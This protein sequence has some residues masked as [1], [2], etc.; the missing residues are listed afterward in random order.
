MSQPKPVV[1]QPQ[2]GEVSPKPVTSPLEPVVSQ[3][4]PVAPSPQPGEVSP[5]PVASS[6]QPGEVSPKPVASSPQPGE[7]SPKPVASSPKP[8]ASSPRP[9][10]AP[11]P[12]SPGL[13]PNNQSGTA[14]EDIAKATPDLAKKAIESASSEKTGSPPTAPV[15]EAAKTAPSKR[16]DIKSPELLSKTP[17]ELHRGAEPTKDGGLPRPAKS[18]DRSNA[19]RSRGELA[20]DDGTESTEPATEDG[21]QLLDEADSNKTEAASGQDAKAE[22]GQKIGQL[23]D[24]IILER[25]ESETTTTGGI[26]IP[27]NAAEKPDEGHVVAVSSGTV[28]KEGEGRPLE[29]KIGDTVLFGEHSGTEVTSPAAIAAIAAVVAPATAAVTAAAESAG[30]RRPVDL[31]SLTAGFGNGGGATAQ[32]SSTST[33]S[34][35]PANEASGS[36]LPRSGN[37][38]KAP[39]EASDDSS[40]PDDPNSDDDDA[41]TGPRTLVQA[42]Y[43]TGDMYIIAAALRLDPNLSV[44]IL[45]DDSHYVGT[46]K[47]RAELEGRSLSEIYESAKTTEAI[48]RARM[49]KNADRIQQFYLEAGIEPHRIEQVDATEKGARAAYAD[50][51]KAAFPD[52]GTAP[53]PVLRVPGYATSVVQKAFREDRYKAKKQLTGMFDAISPERKAQIDSYRRGLFGDDTIMLL[54]NRKTGFIH[55]PKNIGLDMNPNL[56]DQMVVMVEEDFGGRQPVIIG[57]PPDSPGPS[58]ERRT[59]SGRQLIEYWKELNLSF[60]EQAYFLDQ[61]REQNRAMAA[62]M[63]SGALELPALLGMPTVYFELS[64]MRQKGQRWMKMSGRGRPAG[65]AVPNLNQIEIKADTEHGALLRLLYQELTDWLD[66]WLDDDSGDQPPMSLQDTQ[67]VIDA[68]RD[69]VGPIEIDAGSDDG[70]AT[71]LAIE[72]RN[73]PVV[74]FHHDPDGP[75]SKLRDDNLEELKKGL[76]LLASVRGA[77]RAWPVSDE[78]RADLDRHVGELLGAYGFLPRELDDLRTL[79]HTWDSIGEAEQERAKLID[80]WSDEQVIDHLRRRQPRASIERSGPDGD[81]TLAGRSMPIAELRERLKADPKWVYRLVKQESERTLLADEPLQPPREPSRAEITRLVEETGDPTGLRSLYDLLGGPVFSGLAEDL[82]PFDGALGNVIDAVA[83]IGLERAEQA[84]ELVGPAAFAGVLFENRTSPGR[85]ELFVERLVENREQIEEQQRNTRSLDGALIVDA[86]LARTVNRAALA[87]REPGAKELQRFP[88]RPGEQSQAGQ[89]KTLRARGGGPAR[90]VLASTLGYGRVNGPDKRHLL[91]GLDAESELSGASGELAGGK[92]GAQEQKTSDGPSKTGKSVPVPV[93]PVTAEDRASPAYAEVLKA[94]YDLRIRNARRG[95]LAEL[96][97]VF[98]AAQKTGST[99]VFATGSPALLDALGMHAGRDMAARGRGQGYTSFFGPDGLTVTLGQGTVNVR[100]VE[101]VKLPRELPE[102][103]MMRLAETRQTAPGE[104]KL[105]AGMTLTYRPR[106]SSGEP[107]PASVLGY[108]NT[109]GLRVRTGPATSPVEQVL[110]SDEFDIVLD[111]EQPPPPR[112]EGVPMEEVQAMFGDPEIGARLEKLLD[113]ELAP[114]IPGI[115]HI[116]VRRYVD[117]ID[118]S[119]FVSTIVGGAVRD[120]VGKL[121]DPTDIDLSTTMPAMDVF[122]AMHHQKLGDSARKDGLPQASVLPYWGLAQIER[123]VDSGLDVASL[124]GPGPGQQSFDLA[125]DL[126]SRDFTINSLYY[127]PKTKQVLDPTGKGLDDLKDFKLRWT[128][129]SGEALEKK[130]RHD[131][132]Q[133]RR[134]IKFRMKKYKDAEGRERYLEPANRD[135]LKT[136]N[137]VLRD[138]LDSDQLTPE[139]VA[140]MIDGMG[141]SPSQVLD[142]A[143]HIGIEKGLLERL[144]AIPRGGAPSDASRSPEASSG[145]PAP[146]AGVKDATMA[147]NPPAFESS[148]PGALDASGVL[149]ASGAPSDAAEIDAG[150]LADEGALSDLIDKLKER[151]SAWGHPATEENRSEAKSL[152]E[153]LLRS[154]GVN[155]SIVKR[156][157]EMIMNPA[158]VSQSV[159]S[160]CVP[161][162]ILYSLLKSDLET[163]SHLVAAVFTGRQLGR[164]AS[165]PVDLTRDASKSAADGARAEVQDMARR[166]MTGG[167]PQAGDP[168]HNKLLFNGLKTAGAKRTQLAGDKDATASLD[169]HILDHLLGRSLGKLLRLHDLEQYKKDEATTE[170]AKPGY[171]A[172]GDGKSA[173][174]SSGQGGP[175]KK[176][177]DLL[178]SANSV[179]T[180]V[181]KPLGADATVLVAGEDGDHVARV[182]E[183]LRQT[184]RA[185]FAFATVLDGDALWK[186]AQKYEPG[187]TSPHDPARAGVIDKVGEVSPHQVTID[188]EITE[189]GDSYIVPIQSWGRSF[190]IQV[191]K[192]V[193]PELFV[194]FTVGTY[195]PAQAPAAEALAD[196]SDAP[197]EPDAGVADLPA[198]MPAPATAVAASDTSDTSSEPDDPMSDEDDAATGPRTIVQA[199]YM[200]GDM[201]IISA[202][203]RLDPDLSIRILWDNSHYLR[204]IEERAETEGRSVDEIYERAKTTP[205]AERARMKKN[206]DRIRAFY[207]EAGIDPNRIELVDVTEKGARAAYA[208]VRDAAFPKGGTAPDPVLRVPGYA[209]SVVQREFRKDRY[210]ARQKLAGMFEGISEERRGKID[211]YRKD[212]FGDSNIMLVWNRATGWT[213]GRKNIGLDTNPNLLDQMI[214]M[215]EEDFNGRLPVIIGDQP[216]DPGPSAKRIIEAP[217]LIEYWNKL[218]LSLVEQAYFLDQLREQNRAMAAGMI[219]GALELPALLGMPTVYFELSSMRQKGQRWTKMSGLGRP[220]GGAIP[221]LNQIE[222]K[223]DTE[224]GALLRLAYKELEEWLDDTGED[225]ARK[226]MS[227]EE[228]EKEI[229]AIRGVAQPT[230]FNVDSEAYDTIPLSD[231]IVKARKTAVAPFYHDPDDPSSSDAAVEREELAQA[232]ERL[233]RVRRVYRAGSVSK[234]VRGDL[235]RHRREHLGSYGFL[236]QELDDLRTLLRTWDSIGGA[237]QERAK[238][239][240]GWSDEQVIDHL[241]RRQPRAS[242]VRSDPGGD[243]TLAGRSMPIAELRERLKADPKW[244]YRLVKQES[245][246]TLLADEPLQLPGEPSRADIERIGQETKNPTGVEHLHELLGGPV[247]SGLVEDLRPFDGAL[248]SVIDA[249]DAIGPER[250]KQAVEL[251]GPAAF[252]GALF[253]NRTSPGRLELFVER[254]VENREQIE[255]QQRNTR[256]LDGALIVDARLARTVNRAALAGREPGAKELQRFPRR[257]GEQSQAGQ[258]KT[259]RA[260]GGGP[261]RE[262]LASTLGYSRV[263]GPDRRHLLFGL[264]AESELSSASGEL[265]GGKLGAQEQKKQQKTSDGPSKTGKSVPVPVLPV[266]AEDRASPAYA[267]VLKAVYDLRIRNARRSDLAELADVFFAAQKTRSTPV[268]ATGSPALL[269]ALGMHAGR[270]MAARKRGQGY[271]SF[272]GPDGLTVTLGQGTVNVRPVEAVKL[273]RELP[274]TEMMRLAETRKT[275]PGEQKLYAGMTLT[276]RRHGS[277]D[278]PE[279]A[280]VLGY[281]HDGQIR[282]RTGPATSPVEQVLSFDGYDIVLDKEQPPP[283]SMNGVPVADVQEMFGDPE[284]GARLEK[285]LD[286][287]LAPEIP[288]IEHIPVRRYVDMID[289]SGFISTIVGGAVRDVV[290]KLKDPTDIDL[291][292]TM[293]AMDVFTAMHQ[294]KLGDSARKDGLPQAS[295]LPYWGLAQ[296]ER[297]VDSG[298][299]VASLHGPGPGQQSFDLKEDLSSRDF[300]INSLYYD[301]KTKQVLDPTGKGLDDLKDFKLRWTSGS[302]EALEKKLRH[303]PPQIR[304]WIKFRMKKYKDAEGGERYL[305][306]ANRDD[307]KT[308]NDVLRDLLDS[309]QLTPED[310]AYM[311]DGMGASPSQVLDKAEHIGIEKGLLERLFAIPRGG[312]PSDASRSSEASSGAPAPKAGVKDATMAFSPPAFESSVLD[313]LG[314]LDAA[315]APSDAAKVDAG[316]L[317]DEGALSDLIDKLRE[318]SSTWGHPATEENRSEAKSLL[319]DLLRSQGVNPSIVKRLGEMIM[320]PASVSQSVF[321]TCV[322]QG[323]LYSLLKSDLETFSHL[324]AAVFTGRQLGRFASAPVDLTRD[325]SKSAAD[326]AKAEV[327]DMARRVMRGG[328]PQAGDPG[329]N[330]LLFNGLKTAGAKRTQLAG[331]KDATASLDRHVLDHLLGRSLGKLLRLHDLEQYKKDEATTEQAKPG[332]RAKGDGARATESS[333]Q[334]GPVKKQGDLLLSANSVATIVSKPLGA[335]A[336]VLVA[337]E[338]GDHVARVNEV[339]RQADRAPFAFA[340]VLDGEALWKEAQKYEPGTTSPHDAARAG[341]IDKVDGTSPHQVTIDGEITEDGDSYIVP[342]QSWGRSFSIQVKKDVMPEL[343]AAFTVGT[344]VPA[345]APAA[346]ALTKPADAPLGPDAGVADLP[347]GMPASVTGVAASDTSDTSSEPDD[348]ASDKDDAYNGPRTIVQAAYMTGDMYIITAALRLDPNLSVE[349]LW[350]DSHYVNTSKEHAKLEGRSLNEIYERS[351]TTEA[352]E[353]A[354]MKKNADRIEQFYRAAGIA[355]DRIKQVDAREKG[356]RAAY[357]EVRKAAFPKDGTEPDATL[358]VPGH[359]TSVVQKAFREDRYKAKK[360]LTAMFDAISPDRKKEIEAY[361]QKQFGDDPIMLLW[362]RKTGFIHG[363]KNIGLDTNPNL[364]DQMV[365]MVE[366][367]FK[368]RTP[369]ILGDQPDSPG[370]SVERRI[371]SGRQL[372]EYWKD[373]NLS[374]VE[375]AYFLDQLREHNRAMAAGMISGA[376]ELPALL[377]MPTVYFELSSMRQKAQRWMK[378]SGRGRPTGGAVPNLNQIEIKAD[379]EHGALLRLLHQELTDW[380]DGWLDD[381]D[382]RDLPPMSLEQTEA[383]IAAIRDVVEPIE[384]DDGSGSA[385]A[386]ARA[387]EMQK[388]LKPVIPF[389]HDPDGPGS[390]ARDDNLRALTAALDLVTLVRDAHRAWPVSDEVR[391]DLELHMQKQL[392]AYGFLLQELDDLRTMLRSWDSIGEAERERAKLIDGWSDEQVIDHLRRR[393][394]RASIERSDPG[395]EVVLA[396]SSFSVAE[397]RER[398]KADPKWVYGLVKEESKRTLLADTPLELPGEPSRAD[399]ERIGQETKNPTGVEHLHELLGGPVFSGLVEDLRPFKGALGNV[400]DAVDRIGPERAEQAV[401]LVG[402]AAFAGAL[403]E[404]RTSPGRLELFVERLVANRE[405]LE[406]QQRATGSVDGVLVVDANLARTMNR[407]ALAGREPGAAALKRFPR[408]PGE[409]SQA[410]QLQALRGP[411]GGEPRRVLASTLGY[412]RVNGPDKEHLLFGLDSQEE[413]SRASGEHDQDGAQPVGDGSTGKSVP[414]PV[415]PV[416]AEDRASPAYAEVLKAVY[417]LRIRNA[418]RSDLA[419]LAD[420][421]FAA[422]KTGATPVLATGSSALLDALGMHAGR[423]MEARKRKQSYT[424]FFGPEGLTVTLGQGTVNVRPVEAVKLPRQLSETELMR[425]AESR[426]TAPGEQKLYAGMTL[427]YRPRGSSGERKPASV[428]GYTHDGQLRVR[429]GPETSPAEQELSF[430]GYDIVLD[431]KQ[432]PPPSMGGVPVA[433]VQK[434]FA[435]DGIG[436]RLEELLDFGLAPEITEI[437]HFPVRRYV[438]MI[439]RSGFIATIVGG[440]VRDVVGKLKKP[441]DI[442]LSTTM[443]AMDVFAAMHHQ[444]LGDSARKGGLPQAS[445]LPYWG[446]AQIERQVDSGLDVASLHGPGPGQQSFDLKEDLSSR[447]F[448][449]NSLYYDPRTKQVVDPTGKG[450]DDLKDRKLRWTSVSDEALE[451]KLRHDPSQIRRWIKFRMKKY[452]VEGEGE[453]YL[454]PA[455]PG[456]LGIINKVLRD[457][458]DSDQLTPEEVAYMIDGMGATPSQVLDKADHI[459]IE[460]GLL[461]RLFAIPRGGAPSDA[462]RSPEASR[463]APAPKAGVKDATMAF[464]PPAFESS[465]LGAIEESGVPSDAAEI[466]AGQLADESALSGLIDKLR[467]RSSTWGHP[468]TEENRSEAKSLLED[469]L[470]SQGVNPSIVK[471][472][473]EMITNPASVSQSVFSTCVPQGILYSLLKSDLETFSHLV[474]AVFTG[475]QLGRF[476]SAPV[477]LT[478]DASKSAADGAKAE[479]QD[480]ARRVMR[481]GLPQAGDPGHNKLLFNGLKTAGAKRTQLAGDK[482]ATASLDRHILDHLLGRS[483]GKLLRL[484]DLEQYKKDE[485]TTEQAK[486]GYRAKGDDARATESSGQGGPAKKQGDLLLSA[487][488]AATIVSKPLGADATV[489]VAGEDGDHVARVNEV[490]RQ[491]DRAPFAFATVLDGDALWKEAQKYEPGTTSPHDAARAGVID[492]VDGTSPHQVTIDGEI[493]EDG[494]SYIVPIQS[495]GRS[496]SIQVKKDVMPELFAAF[497]V[498]TYVPAQAPAAEALT[499]PADAPLGPDAGVA[500]LPAG[501][502]RTARPALREI[503]ARLV[504]HKEHQAA[505]RRL[506]DDEGGPGIPAQIREALPLMSRDAASALANEILEK[507][508]TFNPSLLEDPSVDLA[509]HLEG[510][511]TLVLGAFERDRG[512]WTIGGDGSSSESEEGTSASSDTEGSLGSRQRSPSAEQRGAERTASDGSESDSDDS[513][514]TASSDGEAA[515]GGRSS[516][517]RTATSGDAGGD[518][519]LDAFGGMELS[520]DSDGEGAAPPRQ[521]TSEAEMAIPSWIWDDPGYRA[522]SDALVENADDEDVG[523]LLTSVLANQSKNAELYA[524]TLTA[525]LPPASTLKGAVLVQALERALRP[526]KQLREVAFDAAAELGALDSLRGNREALTALRNPPLPP[527]PPP[528]RDHESPRKVIERGRKG[529]WLTG[530]EAEALRGALGEHAFAGMLDLAMSKGKLGGI[531]ALIERLVEHAGRMENPALFPPLTSSS[532]VVDSN[533]VDALLEPPDQ[534]PHNKRTARAQIEELIR[535]HDIKDLRLANVGVGETYQYDVIGKDFVTSDGESIP[536]LGVPLDRGARGRKGDYE[537]GFEELEQRSVG[538]GK[539]SADRSMLADAFFS[540]RT[541]SAVPHF[542]TNDQGILRPL[543]RFGGINPDGRGGMSLSELVESNTDEGYFSPKLVGR[544]LAAHVIENAP[545]PAR[546]TAE[547]NAPDPGDTSDAEL[548]DMRL[549]GEHRVRDVIAFIRRSGYDVYIV[550]GAVRDPMLDKTQR[551]VDLKTNMPLSL[552]ERA[553]RKEAAFGA[554]GINTVPKQRLLKF[555]GD[556]NVLDISTGEEGTAPGPLDVEADALKRDFRMNALYMNEKGYVFDPLD[557]GI[558]DLLTGRLRFV[559]DPGPPAS[560]EE[561]QEAVVDYLSD[562]PWVLGRVLKFY[563]RGYELEPEILDA[564]RENAVSIVSAMK[565]HPAPLAEKSLFLHK[566]GVESPEHL[567]EVMEVLGFPREAIR[568]LLPDDVAGRFDDRGEA[569]GRDILPRQRR[570]P[571]DE[572]SWD[573]SSGPEMKVD[574]DTGRIYQYRVHATAKEPGKADERVIIDVDLSDHNMIGHSAPHYHVYRWRPRKDGRPDWVKKKNGFSETGQPGLPELDGG[575]YTGPQPWRFDEGLD[576]ADSPRRFQELASKSIQ[577]AG[578]PLSRAGELWDLG[579]QVKL[580]P[581]RLRELHDAGQFNKLLMLVK[582]LMDGMPWSPRDQAILDL[583]GSHRG[584]Q[585]LRFKPQLDQVEQ[586]LKDSGVK[587]PASHPLFSDGRGAIKHE[588]LLRVYDLAASDVPMERRV[589]AARFA[590]KDAEDFNGFVERFEFYLTTGLDDPGRVEAQWERVQQVVK[591]AGAVSHAMLDRAKGVVGSLSEKET[592]DKLGFA[593]ESAAAYH[594]AKHVADFT[595]SG[596]QG[597]ATAQDVQR[598]LQSARDTILEHDAVERTTDESGAVNFVFWKRS[599]KAVVRVGRDGRAHLVTSFVKGGRRGSNTMPRPARAGRTGDLAGESSGATGD[600]SSGKSATAELVKV[601]PVM[602]GSPARPTEVVLE[603]LKAARASWSRPATGDDR[604]EAASL[605]SELMRSRGMDGALVQRMGELIDNPESLSQHEFATCALHGIVYALL[606]SDFA[607]FTRMAEAVFTDKLLDQ[608]GDTVL[609]VSGKAPEGTTKLLSNAVKKIVNRRG[610]AAASSA[611][612]DPRTLDYVLARSLG[613]VLRELAPTQYAADVQKAAEDHASYRD[614]KADG[615]APA[616][617]AKTKGDLL[618]SANSVATILRRAFGA[619]PTIMTGDGDYDI[620]RVNEVFNGAEGAP[621]AFATV[622]DWKALYAEA[623]KYEAGKS[624]DRASDA[625]PMEQV[626]DSGAHQVVITGPITETG[627]HYTVPVYSWGRSFPMVVK[628]EVMK[629]LFTAVTYGSFTPVQGQAPESPVPSEGPGQAAVV[630]GPPAPAHLDTTAGPPPLPATSAPRLASGADPGPGTSATGTTSSGERDLPRVA[631]EAALA[632]KDQILS[633]AS[634]RIADA[635]SILASAKMDTVLVHLAEDAATAMADRILAAARESTPSGAPAAGTAALEG[636]VAR[637]AQAAAIAMMDRVLAAAKGPLAAGRPH[638]VPGG[639]VDG[640][641]ARIAQGAATAMASRIASTTGGP[642]ADPF[643]DAIAEA[644][645]ARKQCDC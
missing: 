541:A 621:F 387:I 279:P 188:G 192:D 190:S 552:L 551:D 48:E 316:Q 623:Q 557:G 602:T 218:G 598:Y 523:R 18:G 361:R 467:E 641:I 114:E 446:L 456:D 199:A 485:A 545:T 480:M 79:L 29:V 240:D 357:A 526:Y 246:R 627:A 489:L 206:A 6:P 1:P 204:T 113:F 534:L 312:A 521:R 282:V 212:F 165:A 342:I 622:Q 579:G 290:G 612:R 262:V 272:F 292:T 200:T 3:P 643:L 94:V 594:V 63:I 640:A 234:E 323:I 173:S 329:H 573:P 491:A 157:G 583:S 328:L 321:S 600:V 355:P 195:V 264:D 633:A 178:L 341:V 561:R 587:N 88:R 403:F 343:F 207:I 388:Q 133:I 517:G 317:V 253:E 345:Q 350:D 588:A 106:N 367:D 499:K 102:T 428:L 116:P 175:S 311:I 43:M 67:A 406:E 224:H 584:Q 352:I 424:S 503:V 124:H 620:T 327:Q 181:T 146:N 331:D 593:S 514:T 619:A 50:V 472:L 461:E 527:P 441:T 82:G 55:G 381:D 308:I 375:Q 363:P 549:G 398:L 217:Q 333:G 326:G 530:A 56:L 266:T 578:I 599:T 546:G 152:L 411:R 180:I 390:E 376:L 197:L 21:A 161:Q 54:W 277:G 468:A 409:K 40:E 629:D 263:N 366:D 495:W 500:N 134:W 176:Q 227:P 464:S 624:S 412:G 458:L 515:P 259:L 306:P 487:N 558:E 222:I 373:L 604:Q 136:I 318:R 465:A 289:R 69:A 539:G 169:R 470:R 205:D 273:P 429:T 425:L 35:A 100:P 610:D 638:L 567:I 634:G 483:L 310:V 286:F 307:L 83:T 606:K 89:L 73:K 437:K 374:F 151:S 528:P 226:S 12:V 645:V 145:A 455:N 33:S 174:E 413:L 132:P 215:I 257:P 513:S 459:G 395:G 490:L 112:V 452:E 141:A 110:S 92:P 644:L 518:H 626:G 223:A 209:T 351:G 585:R 408:R 153:D 81:V 251:V 254:L 298:L 38:V 23:E 135:D 299:D 507:W 19:P 150:Q 595:P 432:P 61:L 433:D 596:Q 216:Q 172:K 228:T 77:H 68:I 322:P 494:D 502:V 616:G 532:L 568:Q 435:D 303:D 562:E 171:R 572:A 471:R 325:A 125:E 275:A 423:D 443:P 280:S 25:A 603:A 64:S 194:A 236:Q 256:S 570:T 560:I 85:L 164:F 533:L 296:I 419:E 482:D 399:I 70:R 90:E 168:G 137:D 618:T 291:S 274:E 509:P 11:S 378:M 605:L 260:R 129:G 304:R 426:E 186:E 211:G 71:E 550:G 255:E 184:D 122:T 538:E 201:Y 302:G 78:V 287:E 451:A 380:L 492:K 609:D 625:A 410:D 540:A 608:Q 476:A 440:A 156:L 65:G 119:G 270:D 566:T 615:E 506:F 120:V 108:N 421:F 548:L 293:P 415:L 95:D 117:M 555:G 436:G 243:V 478:R 364:L 233:A 93:L 14:I 535:E 99:P 101:A 344:Y 320:N 142:K 232:L 449:I 155:P 479:V 481:G 354:R 60:V 369:V 330:K 391:I 581:E 554:L 115:E 531:R 505:I 384:T 163:F 438:D 271:T 97:D 72:R 76:D 431:K 358:R 382:G 288:G 365:V 474:A 614:K 512:R 265:A 418:R 401:E 283:P 511:F 131:P 220:T 336:T 420:V 486:P 179:A 422:Q 473:G 475:R 7:V 225:V 544:E 402:P 162:G 631:Q 15:T 466:D 9:T 359:A 434:K 245:E 219:S 385:R 496:F 577:E 44:R 559:A 372:I 268:F 445:V 309:D 57:D 51:R 49:K 80:G 98:F 126:S 346:E 208:E 454:E 508:L 497:T 547:R 389:H 138:L 249:V 47:E 338:D 17:E 242:I 400:I 59:Q 127:D 460:K 488:S 439:E 442:D 576:S 30:K 238:L 462:S 248:G 563:Q 31:A 46:S 607:G 231:P 457:L 159:F 611:M 166:V 183:V 370:P 160:T 371:R 397:L 10:T 261:A 335:D 300:T 104:Q 42:A 349:I 229:D 347:A 74:P 284:I 158:S 314:A 111:E 96:A 247:F 529:R 297:Q 580:H 519:L 170:Q 542:A 444:K 586:F 36:G 130:L 617:V 32:P 250:A 525:A 642:V 589:P 52:D 522:L 592:V 332:Y 26:I 221:N 244:V 414:V 8:V 239:I 553:L 448:T 565:E 404:N 105:Y 504:P 447:D 591:G 281:T 118:R 315:G 334:G 139:D 501:M 571:R 13:A 144:F 353:R 582:N 86:R 313:A 556:E 392:G 177:G 2:P 91:F 237:E 613:R 453:F 16:G 477:D 536:W 123:Q 203:L 252:A 230:V 109:G 5:K 469:V 294:H 41:T 185:P 4:K 590:L 377:G 210:G 149:D 84:V 28:L 628:K 348:P 154:Q 337:G 635:P 53:D 417:D 198:G 450:L 75:G 324:V 630:A 537:K 37:V 276:Y 22:S 143:D 187:T 258:L 103:E 430:D 20:E 285:L 575:E 383:V 45:W 202:A 340:T 34:G 510:H 405:Q 269:D 396:G 543:L 214:E 386:R 498:G 128:S 339:L 416:T 235:A 24:R 167:L 319:E 148:A 147:F 427:T 463:G 520:S 639:E 193:M 107:K 121:K 305:E 524:K 196:Q 362:N 632:M 182:N 493:T 191:K 27:D 574:I 636:S 62:G 597:R 601:A 379:T 241:R 213:H 58:V 484:H 301:P 87:G 39:S 356:A 267:E 637:I 368:G 394:P 295:V 569:F 66:G 360:Q 278:E 564:V 407:T 189:D 516:P 140:Y 393:Q